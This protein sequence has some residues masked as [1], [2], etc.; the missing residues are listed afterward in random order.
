M[1]YADFNEELSGSYSKNGISFASLLNQTQLP[2]LGL[3]ARTLLDERQMK[4]LHEIRNRH[5]KSDQKAS[6]P[7]D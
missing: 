5:L 6:F 4:K 2:Q 7:Q 1:Y 3:K